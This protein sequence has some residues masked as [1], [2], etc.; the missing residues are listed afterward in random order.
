MRDR[1][2]IFITLKLLGISWALFI[3]AEIIDEQMN[4]TILTSLVT[5]V[6]PFAF[7]YLYVFMDKRNKTKDKRKGQRRIFGF[8]LWSIV[9][10]GLGYVIVGFIENDMWISQQDRSEFETNGIEYLRYGVCATIF[11]I[12]MVILIDVF[13]VM[14]DRY[15]GKANDK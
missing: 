3:V 1:L 7:A 12:I 11:F 5:F 14:K 2:S 15:F 4:K 8:I 10:M 6:V 9:N 13:A